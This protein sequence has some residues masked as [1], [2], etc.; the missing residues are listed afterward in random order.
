MKQRHLPSSAGGRG[1]A[2]ASMFIVLSTA[3]CASSPASKVGASEEGDQECLADAQA[4]PRAYVFSPHQEAAIRPSDP[5]LIVYT[6]DQGRWPGVR[7]TLDDE[8]VG[9]GSTA[10][11]GYAY[12]EVACPASFSIQP[13]CGPSEPVERQCYALHPRL[14]A[15]SERL[16][17]A[18]R[19]YSLQIEVDGNSDGELEATEDY[20]IVVEDT[21]INTLEATYMDLDRR[22]FSFRVNTRTLNEHQ[23]QNLSVLRL[24]PGGD[25]ALASEQIVS[26]GSDGSL[27]VDETYQLEVEDHPNFCADRCID[28]TYTL[29]RMDGQPFAEPAGA[30]LAVTFEVRAHTERLDDDPSRLQFHAGLDAQV[31]APDAG[32]LYD[33]QDPVEIDLYAVGYAYISGIW[34][35]GQRVFT[36]ISNTNATFRE[37]AFTE[38]FSSFSFS[39]EEWDTSNSARL[40]QHCTLTSGNE[41]V[42]GNHGLATGMNHGNP[43]EDV[44]TRLVVEISG[45]NAGLLQARERYFSLHRP[46]RNYLPLVMEGGGD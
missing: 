10:M 8:L 38:P 32:V 21:T 46:H 39:C 9:V 43:G 36:G 44:S 5:V 34:L 31:T 30:D 15:Q 17:S 22:S 4:E 41:A 25:G 33:A 35:H 27:T 19:E 26:Q 1:A 6:K 7:L 18:G 45:R 28:T 14:N 13:I 24:I 11:N 16:F 37:A 23:S 40:H 29:S 20:R 2:L 12:D 3:G 42:A